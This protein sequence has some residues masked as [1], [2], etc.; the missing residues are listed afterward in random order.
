[1]HEIGELNGEIWKKDAR[2]YQIQKRKTK[3][4]NKIPFSM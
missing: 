1:M 3:H 4:K 2:P